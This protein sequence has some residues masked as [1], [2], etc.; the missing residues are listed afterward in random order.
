MYRNRF[1]NHGSRFFVV[2]LVLSI[3]LNGTQAVVLCMGSDQHVAIELAGHH[4]CHSEHESEEASH[5]TN[6]RNDEL[7]PP[8]RPCV[9]VPLSSGISDGPVV[10]KTQATIALFADIALPN[11]MLADQDLETDVAPEACPAIASF[12]DPLSSIILIE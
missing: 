9:D 1:L 11:Q 3:A 6:D 2:L 7:D 5:E 10:H 12:Y 4:H 8:C